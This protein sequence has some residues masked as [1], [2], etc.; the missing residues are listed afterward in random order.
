MNDVKFGGG[1]PKSDE[2]EANTS[3]SSDGE[4]REAAAIATA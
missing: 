2:N 3:P 1:S 4:Q